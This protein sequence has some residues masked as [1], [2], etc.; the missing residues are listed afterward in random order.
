[1][2]SIVDLQATVEF[3]RKRTLLRPQIGLVLGSSLG[4]F[5]KEIEV[6]LSIPFNEI[7]NFARPTV[8]GHLG[9]LIFGQVA[10]K[11]IVA[12]QGRVHYYEGHSM[13]AVAF[14]VRVMA[15]LGIQNLILT[16]SA[17]GIL[18]GMAPGDF[19]LIE[20]HVNLMGSNPLMGAHIRELGPRFPDL[21]QTYDP[22]FLAEMENL[23]RSLGYTY[24]K[25]PYAGVSGPAF[26]TRAEVKYLRAI[27]CSAVG[28]SIVPEAIAA[29]HL[30]VRVAAISCITNV[31]SSEPQRKPS[32]EE[33][34][35]T[36]RRVESQFS[37]FMKSFLE[38]L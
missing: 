9:N 20:D 6:S 24:H 29:V 25:G 38:R 23:L 2:S 21:N 19:F 5:A 34:N 14:P 32:M 1:M 28:M 36:A 10:G 35:W 13:D 7:P 26:E 22:R 3:L 30:G 11:Q 15:L 4:A 8:D 18:P 31:V 16:N 27:G 37:R 17:G 12:L 33:F